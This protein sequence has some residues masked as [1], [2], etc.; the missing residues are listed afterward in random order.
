MSIE[1][2]GYNQHGRT[3]SFADNGFPR[4]NFDSSAKHKRVQSM[5]HGPLSNSKNISY[6]QRT[7]ED[8]ALD[9]TNNYLSHRTKTNSSNSKSPHSNIP[10]QEESKYFSGMTDRGI[11]DFLESLQKFQK[12]NVRKNLSIEIILN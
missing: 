2:P 1:S 9:E 11:V 6:I 4:R 8:F 3:T 7:V 10:K 5:H 12:D